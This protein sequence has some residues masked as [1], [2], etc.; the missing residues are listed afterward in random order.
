MKIKE[1]KAYIKSISRLIV[2][3]I[4]ALALP[5]IF[6]AI[7]DG[8]LTATVETELRENYEVLIADASYPTDMKTRM[9][10]IADT[11]WGNLAVSVENMNIDQ[12]FFE[13]FTREVLR[14]EYME[15]LLSLAED[16]IKNAF[17]S[18]SIDNL[19]ICDRYV[20]YGEDYGILLSF[21]YMKI[22]LPTIES[23]VEFIVDTE[24][25]SIYYVS[26]Y[27]DVSNYYTYSITEE[28]GPQV[29]I[30]YDNAEDIQFNAE[31]YVPTILPD[32]EEKM[33]QYINYY[34]QYYGVDLNLDSYREISISAG[35][36]FISMAHM[37][38]Y[39]KNGSIMFRFY[40]EQDFGNRLN[41]SLGIPR[42]RQLVQE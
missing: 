40:A 32:M 25:F 6:F 17:D 30:V 41:I 15:Y 23:H 24:T 34:E 35:D 7:Q 13:N 9:S 11:G 36:E 37:L 18:M 27:E 5:N 26:L 33:P 16:E 31:T 19:K 2:L 39:G 3:I 8:Y 20:V 14:Q 10:R 22:Y 42:I 21:L 1:K 38:S 29:H 28:S 4:I 12:E